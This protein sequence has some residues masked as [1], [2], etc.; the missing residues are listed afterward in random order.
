MKKQYLMAPGPTTIPE[1][2]LAAE[3]YPII[4]HRTPGFKKVLEEVGEGL[5]YVFQTQRDVYVH[6]SSGTGAMEM[7]VC[8]LLSKGDKALVVQGGKFG[9]RWAEICQAYG[10]E[11][12]SIDIP[13]GDVVTP[14]MI[15][16]TLKG[17]TS[18]KAVYTTHC[19]TSTG[20][21]TDIEGIAEVVRDHSA[22]L[23]VDAISGLGAEPLKTDEWGIDVVV[24]GSQKG[25]MIP[26][27]LSFIS[28]SEKAWELVKMSDLPKYYLSLMALKESW[29][30][31]DTPYTPAVSLIMALQKSLEMIKKEGL[32]NVLSRHARLAQATREGI[33]ALDL[34]LFAK[35]P[36]NNC[37]AVKVPEGIDGKVI[38]K[39]FRDE[40]GITIAGGQGSM[41]GKIFRIAHLGY[42]DTFDVVV[43]ISALEMILLDLGCPIELGKGVGAA[44]R[45]LRLGG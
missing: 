37:T 14:S 17:D 36:A 2:V 3:S 15:G 35:R 18:I 30:K 27:G 19:E 28:L 26:P 1:E 4:H 41:K 31:I 45:V 20:V 32:E 23:V 8:N 6:A 40:Y 25:L 39:R 11:V 24:A 34:E 5:R 42:A 21:V 10:I 16:E 12:V 7:A 9:E 33:L 44:E 13:Y 22:V 43:A 29:S 38:P